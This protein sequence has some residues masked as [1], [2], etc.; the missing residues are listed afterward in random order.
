MTAI[1]A[2]NEVILTYRP[3]GAARDCFGC[4][5]RE[6]CLDGPAGTGKTRAA[7]EKLHAVLIKYPGARGLMLRKTH[8][9]LKSTALVTY[10]EKVL[11][12]L[13]RVKFHG[14]NARQPAQFCY[15]NG[16]SLVVGGLD[17]PD[18]IMSSEYDCC[19]VNEATDLTQ[20]DWEAITTRLRNGKMPY[21]QLIG[22]CN[23]Q[24]PQH[25]LHQRMLSGLTTRLISRHE[26]NP[27]ITPAYLATLQALTGVR[28]ARLF[29][30][31]W[32]AAEGGIYEEVW[33]PAL[34][35]IDR[36]PI[37]P[38]W[39]RYLAVDF[40]YNHAFV[41]QWWAIDDDG[42]AYR[43][44]EIYHTKR[45]VEDHAAT[46]REISRFGQDGGDPLPVAII[47]DHDA[48]DRAT[49][50]RH[51]GLYTLPAHKE[52]SPGLQAVAS[53]LRVAGDGKPRLYFLRDSLVERD[54]ELTD[55]KLPTCSE[56]E[57]EGYVW[58]TRQQRRQGEAPLKEHDHGCD[59]ARYLVAHL[60]LGG[61]DRVEYGY[62]LF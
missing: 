52:V 58:D 25:W 5:D 16:S 18:K 49:L 45:L 28:R 50:E 62:Q 53:R 34:H 38:S 41:C 22:D 33:N 24:G 60:D 9:S 21:Q 59:A 54:K 42:R 3:R 7:L 2:T 55:R 27:T 46:I 43:Y 30:G 26:D 17:K 36:F 23:P 1:A 14:G 44:R 61:A 37:P 12:L 8:S 48:E 4:R 35:L 47:C 10:T 57:I 15:P 31:H 56:E 20:A 19:Y 13:D 51:L 40:G 29:L 11:H 39:P 32:A 6:V